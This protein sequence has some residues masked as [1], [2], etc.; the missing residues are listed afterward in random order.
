MSWKSIKNVNPVQSFLETF[1]LLFWLFRLVCVIVVAQMIWQKIR[2]LSDR[3][4]FI[5][6]MV[7]D[8]DTVRLIVVIWGKREA[9]RLPSFFP[10]TLLLLTY[11]SVSYKLPQQPLIHLIAHG[12]LMVTDWEVKMYRV[13]L[14]R[15]INDFHIWCLTPT[16]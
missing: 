12:L 1:S 6:K 10:F 15:I 16:C 4:L 2:L 14:G 13:Q 3:M 8:W 11:Y 9:K 7:A 5:L